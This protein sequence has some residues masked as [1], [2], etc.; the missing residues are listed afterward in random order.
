MK[1]YKA[2]WYI[3]GSPE[4][5]FF[6]TELN[7]DSYD[8]STNEY[9][10]DNFD[11]IIAT[12]E[13]ADWLQ[14]LGAEGSI[15]ISQMNMGYDT[16]GYNI[17]YKSISI[18]DVT[19]VLLIDNEYFTIDNLSIVNG[20]THAV[21]TRITDGSTINTA[22]YATPTANVTGYINGR[23]TPVG[24]IGKIYDEEDNLIK[25]VVIENILTNGHHIVLTVGSIIS[26]FDKEIPI[27]FNVDIINNRVEMRDLLPKIFGN[28]VTF[29][30]G[31]WEALG[32]L[33][34]VQAL[35]TIEDG[36]STIINPW[37]V[38]KEIVKLRNGY[39]QLRNGVYHVNFISLLT[40]FA[41]SLDTISI[42][43]FMM[44][45]G[46]YENVL[47]GTSTKVE[48]KYKDR[49]NEDEQ[50][51][52][53]ESTVGYNSNV[54]EVTKVEI[55]LT[56]YLIDASP[57]LRPYMLDS[58]TKLRGLVFGYLT[59][60][61]TPKHTY[62][63]G[64]KY[65]IEEIENDNVKNFTFFT[66]GTVSIMALCYSANN[67]EVKFLLVEK[68]VKSP[69]SPALYMIATANDTL[70][71]LNSDTVHDYLYSDRDILAESRNP[72]F[73]YVYFTASHTV[74]S[75]IQIMNSTD[76]TLHADASVQDSVDNVITV[77]ISTLI[78]GAKYIVEYRNT[79]VDN[80][81]TYHLQMKGGII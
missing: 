22:H 1:K 29:Q 65:L 11:I 80:Y 54:G 6:S 31:F 62:T 61:V 52:T 67:K 66:P 19:D 43:D 74:G 69:I 42:Y 48:Y 35:S 81:L 45:H 15:T 27:A 16:I 20:Q 32:H 44:L 30:D 14:T 64:D 72:D 28:L 38:L 25:T 23:Y 77:S 56:K 39:I 26:E 63:I 34:L 13:R 5:E 55:D 50:T 8:F 33:Q 68:I 58:I 75:T 53:T 59:I 24:I 17:T 10:Y 41:S 12:T 70:E 2:V 46:G 36:R 51:L 73:D 60:M 18:L 76:Y 71:L 78:V 40:P 9:S 57:E 79:G 7:N 4:T 3:P 47:S 37:Q 21:T 49:I